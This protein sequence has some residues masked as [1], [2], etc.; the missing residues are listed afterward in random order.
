MQSNTVY[1]RLVMFILNV[2]HD[3][4]GMAFTFEE[5]LGI[6]YF[7]ITLT[8]PGAHET[9]TRVPGSSVSA[10]TIRSRLIWRITRFALPDYWS[11]TR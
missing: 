11:R 4:S 5:Y 6:P 7:A 1:Y 3:F 10:A 8:E 2:I 9:Q